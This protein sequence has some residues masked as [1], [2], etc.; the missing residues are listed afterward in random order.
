VSQRFGQ[1]GFAQLSASAPAALRAGAED[2]AEMGA[3]A[4]LGNPRRLDGLAG[5]LE[6]FMPFGLV[7]LFI[8]HT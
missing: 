7:P 4:S 5:K 6:E 1:P 8:P 2:G 3:F